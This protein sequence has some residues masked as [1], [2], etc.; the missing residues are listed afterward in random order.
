MSD[1][2]LQAVPVWMLSLRV[3][4]GRRCGNYRACGVVFNHEETIGQHIPNQIGE[5][6]GFIE[7]SSERLRVRLPVL[8]LD[9]AQPVPGSWLWHRW[10]GVASPNH[11]QLRSESTSA[12][13][14]RRLAPRLASRT[15]VTQIG[16]T[17][18]RSIRASSSRKVSGSGFAAGRRGNACVNTPRR[19]RISLA[20]Q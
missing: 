8:E 17:P 13:S 15:R 19:R 20:I 14:A 4:C 9:L 2:P 6:R 1:H 18:S 3:S 10:Y 11:L 5:R 7:C 16:A 12:A